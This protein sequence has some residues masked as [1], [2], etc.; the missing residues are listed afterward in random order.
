MNKIIILGAGLSGSL[1]G[2]RL[3]KIA[4][5]T[6]INPIGIEDLKPVNKL[7]PKHNFPYFSDFEIDIQ[8]ELIFPEDHR[9]SWYMGT[10]STGVVNSKEFGEP[11]GKVVRYDMLIKDLLA[12]TEKAGV[13]IRVGPYPEKILRNSDG[14]EIH[15]M[16]GTPEKA[17]LLIIAGGGATHSLQ[18]KLGFSAPTLYN[19]IN[20]NLE[21]PLE[22]VSNNFQ[23]QYIF[24]INPNISVVG[25]FAM[26]KSQNMVSVGFLG[27]KTESFPEMNEKLNRI[28]KNY[29]KIQA[30]IDGLTPSAPAFPLT[31]SKH[32]IKRMVDD[33][34]MILG[35]SAGLVSGFFYEGI[36]GTLASSKIAS[37]VL[38]DLFTNNKELNRTNLQRYEDT[39]RRTLIN[40]YF[41]TG[42]ASEF[43]FYEAGSNLKLLFNLYGEVLKSSSKARKMLY[44]A[45]INQHLETYNYEADRWVGEQIFQRVP[46]LQKLVLMPHFLKSMNL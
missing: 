20:V 26:I 15:N 16:S 6:L 23:P 9:I 25:P 40:T 7:F 13:E 33:H 14:L 12:K 38:L 44:E 11:M 17:N 24:H 28:L 46:T 42:K 19:G 35:E 29:K 2:L 10:D 3:A 32:P 36:I 34:V 4:H 43:L 45:C 5:V 22:V 21:G 27:N 37:G 39:L 31:V 1:T 8:N 18:S 41:E 30:L